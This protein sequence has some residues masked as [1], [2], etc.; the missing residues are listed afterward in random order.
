MNAEDARKV[1]RVMVLADGGCIYCAST[2]LRSLSEDFPEH[3]EV[4]IEEFAFEYV[5]KSLWE[6]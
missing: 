4:F 1:A 5:G 6:D 3:K 2:L